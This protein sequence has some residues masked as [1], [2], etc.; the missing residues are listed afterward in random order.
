MLFIRHIA[1]ELIGIAF[2]EDYTTMF[3]GIQ[4]SGEGLKGGIFLMEKQPRISVMIR[5]LDGGVIGS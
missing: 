2:S 4:H 5:K 3:A 1:C